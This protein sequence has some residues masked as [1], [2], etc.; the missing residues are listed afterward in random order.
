M[1]CWYTEGAARLDV[2]TILIPGMIISGNYMIPLAKQLASV[3]QTY[4]IDFPGYG[5]SE[6]PPH[7]LTIPELA[8]SIA[9][10]MSGMG[11]SHA[12]F[13][14]NSFGCQILADFASRYPD[15]VDKLVLQGPTVDD[16]ARSFWVQ[17]YR[18]R[19]NAHRE[20]KSVGTISVHDYRIAGAKRVI[21]SI[22]LTLKDH[23]EEKLPR[24]QAPTLVVRGDLDPVVPQEWA[25]HVTRLLPRGELRL[26]HGGAHTL[27]YSEPEKF[28][29][30]VKPFLGL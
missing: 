13:I 9:A 11:I 8:D 10:W 24:I 22:R 29:A 21:R 28:A 6:K 25:E 12:N 3:C 7:V 23:I 17:W 14:A 15:R 20:S 2:V 4:I 1:F 30:V 26:V 27:N 5:H 16:S 19:K 18:L